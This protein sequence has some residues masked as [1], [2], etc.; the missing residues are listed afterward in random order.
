MRV[1]LDPANQLTEPQRKRYYDIV[2]DLHQ[3]QRRGVEAARALT[4]FHTQMTE[5]G[6]KLEGMANVPADVKAQFDAV[7][8]EWD[9]VRVK[10]GVPPAVAAGRRRWAAAAD[11]P[12]TR[13]CRQQGRHGEGPDHG[14]LRPAERLA[15]DAV[16]RRAPGAAEGDHR[17]QRVPGEG[18]GAEPGAGEEWRD[19]DGAAARK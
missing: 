19:A 4:P 17:T 8:K 9:T 6:G 16:R 11:L 12:R 15:D 13:G 5:I 14:V 10:F 7:K 3:M 2:M 1:V 18:H